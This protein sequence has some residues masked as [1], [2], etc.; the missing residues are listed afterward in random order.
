MNACARTFELNTTSP[1]L[2]PSDWAGE[3]YTE[4]EAE[5]EEEEEA[6]AGAD[7]ERLSLGATS[8]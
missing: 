4:A 2:S 8:A 3:G 1:L 5:E 7:R 6:E